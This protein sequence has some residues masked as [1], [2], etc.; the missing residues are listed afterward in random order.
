MASMLRDQELLTPHSRE[1]NRLASRHRAIANSEP[2]SKRVPEQE[3]GAAQSEPSK[4]VHL[5]TSDRLSPRRSLGPAP[6]RAVPPERCGLPAGTDHRDARK[7][8]T[9]GKLQTR[10]V[11]LD[12]EGAGG[13]GGA[14]G[15]PKEPV[16]VEGGQEAG[17]NTRKRVGRIRRLSW[18][19]TRQYRSGAPAWNT[20]GCA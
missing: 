9:V 17:R 16:A 8:S 19:S 5:I 14:T 3:I 15:A 11:I 18:R 13:F 2:S 7:V 1:R 4:A 6:V 12:P 10:R 20:K